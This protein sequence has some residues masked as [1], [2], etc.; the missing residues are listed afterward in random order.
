MHLGGLEGGIVHVVLQ[1][2]NQAIRRT[3]SVV[4]SCAQTSACVPAF[5][6]VQQC[7]VQAA[8]LMPLHGKVEASNCAPP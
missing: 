2:E 3:P 4:R 1:G 7:R 8:H 6:G 5:S